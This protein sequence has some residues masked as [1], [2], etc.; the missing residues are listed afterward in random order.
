MTHILIAEVPLQREGY[1]LEFSA[2]TEWLADLAAEPAPPAT[3]I[4]TQ[5]SFGFG[6]RGR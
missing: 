5:C 4:F 3:I 6:I 1:G 2:L